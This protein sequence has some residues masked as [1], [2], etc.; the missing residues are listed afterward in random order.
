MTTHEVA[1]RFGVSLTAVYQWGREALIQKCYTD[2]L[3][4]GLWQ[5]PDGQTILKGRGGK[6]ARSARLM[7]TTLQNSEQGAV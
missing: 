4:R 1:E 5:L 2:S 3:N 7:P 6:K